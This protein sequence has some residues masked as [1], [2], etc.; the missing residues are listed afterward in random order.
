LFVHGA[1]A[2]KSEAPR[3]SPSGV[4]RLAVSAADPAVVACAAEVSSALTGTCGVSG[5]R[6]IHHPGKPPAPI[7]AIATLQL[8]AR[9]RFQTSL[10]TAGQLGELSIGIVTVTA[11][12]CCCRAH[13]LLHQLINAACLNGMINIMDG[14][15][16]VCC[17]QASLGLP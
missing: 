12:S 13:G 5:F 9:Y 2:Q 3:I 4:L 17:S 15:L 16:G 10:V 6:T 1:P 7:Q 8:L 14:K 11:R